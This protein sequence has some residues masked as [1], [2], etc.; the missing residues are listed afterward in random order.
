[1]NRRPHGA[2]W[3]A[4]VFV[5]LV[6][7]AAEAGA[8]SYTW[9]GG[10]DGR[11]WFDGNNWDPSGPP[12]A[13]DQATMTGTTLARLTN[14]TPYLGAFTIGNA[15]LT[16]TNWATVLR[17]TNVTI[18]SG[19]KLTHV[20]CNTNAVPGGTNRVSIECV[21]L[22][23][24]QGGTINVDKMGYAGGVYSGQGP[25]G[26]RGG[27]YP[28]CGGAGGYG[29]KGGVGASSA[30]GGGTYG[31]AVMPLA[32]GSGG[33]SKGATP[34]AG[35]GGGAIAIDADGAVSVAG[36]LSANGEDMPPPSQNG[37]GAGSGGSVY[38]TCRTFWGASTGAVRADGG[39]STDINY[40]G[41]GGGGRIAI[42]SDPV[43]QAKLGVPPVPLSAAAGAGAVD[44]LGEVGTVYLSNLHLMPCA[45]L[46]G[47]YVFAHFA[48]WTPNSVTLSNAAV[49]WSG[50]SLDVTNG[51]RVMGR[52]TVVV[53]NPVRTRIGG[54][55]TLTNSMFRFASGTNA[56]AVLTVG[57]DLALQ[58]GTALYVSSAAAA[59]AS[60]G[61]CGARV[62]VGRDLTVAGN[63][64]V[65][66]VSDP[67]NGASPL[68]S[69]GNV[70]IEGG[71]Q[72][73]FN[74][75]GAGFAGGAGTNG[76]GP[77][78]GPGG[79][80]PNMPYGPGCGAGYGGRGGCGG[81]GVD[82]AGVGGI[83]YGSSNAPV[84][85]GS[86]GGGTTTVSWRGGR[87]G[88]LVRIEAIGTVALNG[89]ILADG[90]RAGSSGSLA[91]G[92][93]GGGIYIR[94]HRLSGGSQGLL[95][96]NGADAWTG[97]VWNGGGGGGG[98]IAVWRAQDATGGQLGREARGGTHDDSRCVGKP[99]TIV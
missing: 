40:G 47:R 48:A 67:T 49:S 59:N 84:Q 85:P 8:T 38:I 31:S 3:R 58:S 33:G 73:G 6:L 71:T 69:A 64:W 95:R 12:G 93:S 98:R 32:P 92:G 18:Q 56:Q 9:D 97:S 17:A 44:R 89:S 96:A 82:W 76:F 65:Y 37:R 2:A 43:E 25:G 63:A 11:N 90:S 14:A 13:G 34:V 52:S 60:T 79:P 61:A 15:T 75:T 19:G 74:A 36:V 70:R 54:S 23:V 78:F 39:K 50:F 46:N 24:L 1:M 7:S 30:P 80:Y 68:F 88:G 53:T 72:G 35:A 27:A 57:C 77:G 20:N 83:T 22:T 5:S 42:H 99:G 81:Y 21:D 45:L 28:S 26:G 94:C 16:F 62:E 51:L 91:G 10:G 41:T 86:G 87:G 29:G 55:L 66:P 4:L